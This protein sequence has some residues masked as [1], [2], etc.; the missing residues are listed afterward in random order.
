MKKIILIAAF[1]LVAQSVISQKKKYLLFEF[2]KVTPAQETAYL[3][4]ENFWQKIHDQ[5]IKNGEMVEW[6]LWRLE[7]S[8]DNP[9]YQYVTIQVFND[10][11]KM[12]ENGAGKSFLE[13][14]KNAFPEISDQDLIIK[15]NQSLKNR[16]LAET[17]YLEQI[18]ETKGKFTLSPGT[19]MGINL[20]NVTPDNYEKYENA[21]M[22]IFKPEWQNRVDEGRV[23]SWS[24]LK[25]VGPNGSRSNAVFAY[26]SL[27]RYK[28]FNQLFGSS[29]NYNTIRSDSAQAAW[30]DGL[31][32]REI[33]SCKTVLVKRIGKDL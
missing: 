21:E 16:E 14:A 22:K 19:L 18:D 9:G 1:I 31:K 6:Q 12:F 5:R 2:M 33:S 10:A 32:T 11:G 7:P 8:D 3:E 27:D 26:V 13:V 28:D 24:L 23:G 29:N 25:A 17:L 15:R 20:M 4:T 30:Q